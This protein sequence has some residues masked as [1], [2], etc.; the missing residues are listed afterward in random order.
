VKATPYACSGAFVDEHGS[1]GPTR[2][3]G[4]NLIADQ[5]DTVHP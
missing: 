4:G 3:E 2:D 5:A 1:S